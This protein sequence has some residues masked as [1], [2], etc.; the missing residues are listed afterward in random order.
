MEQG[1]FKDKRTRLVMA[2]CFIWGIIAHGMAFFKKFSYHDDVPHFNG[3]GLTYDLGRWFLGVLGE[4]EDR[5]FASR[6]YSMP[7]ING[8]LTILCIAFMLILIVRMLGI[9]DKMII[10]GLAGVMVAFPAVTGI[11]GFIYTAQYYYF[12][13]LLG[14]IG[15]YVYYR[16]R[17]L[18]T[19]I[20]CATLMALSVAVYQSNISIHITVLLLFMLNETVRSDTKWKDWFLLAGRNILICAGF[21]VEYIVLNKIFLAVKGMELSDYKGVSS[22]GMTNPAEYIMRIYSAYKRFLRPADYIIEAEGVS[23]NMYPWSIKYFHVV[24]IIISLVLIVIFI[25]SLESKGQML[26]T[27]LII[28]LSPLFAYSVYVMVGESEVHGLMTY[29]EVFLFFIPAYVISRMGY[30]KGAISLAKKACLV[31]TLAIG[32]LFARY[33][34]ICYLKAQIMQTEAISY[35][36][37]LISRIQSTEGYTNNTPIAFLGDRSK[38]DEDFSGNRLFDPI[39]LP[40][41]QGNSIINDF[42]WKETM[43]MWCGFDWTEADED[44]LSDLSGSVGT[45]PCYPDDGS[46]KMV[47]NV[48][49]VKFSD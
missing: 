30:G 34:N 24:L 6:H 20:V 13:A 36:N 39:Y 46:V 29:G 25:R 10:I 40:P 26:R 37:T 1:I 22:F 41:Y 21:M 16:D 17:C 35:Y 38:N 45:M 42:S 23:A 3:V 5:I 11:F 48:L 44:K 19:G 32:F 28:A 15:A 14:V 2:A 49:V 31:L 33:S 27:G 47:D 7:V 4:V 18:K 12:G 43:K 8:L 9:E